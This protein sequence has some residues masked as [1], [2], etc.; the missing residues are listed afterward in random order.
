MRLRVPLL[1]G[2]RY[3]HV[4]CT[5][6][7]LVCRKYVG[8]VT[9]RCHSNLTVL[10]FQKFFPCLNCSSPLKVQSPLKDED[11]GGGGGGGASARW[12]VSPSLSQ[13]S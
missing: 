3:L 5:A 6:L 4:I 13:L 2:H 11:G 12:S 1:K 10:W 8:I 7:S 9:I